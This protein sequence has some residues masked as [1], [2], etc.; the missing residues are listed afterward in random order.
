MRAEVTRFARRHTE[1]IGQIHVYLGHGFNALFQFSDGVEVFIKFT[2][3]G[4]TELLLE[5]LCILQSKIK[6]ALA[7]SL[8]TLLVFVDLSF[9]PAGKQSVKDRLRIGLRRHG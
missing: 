7:I 3:V 9:A 6:N 4:I 1:T 5:A 2:L 8:T